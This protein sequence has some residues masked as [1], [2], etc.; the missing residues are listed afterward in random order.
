MSKKSRGKVPATIRK[1]CSLPSAIAQMKTIEEV[2][3]YYQKI[4]SCMP[5]NVFWLDKN[6]ITQ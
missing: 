1:K 5:N 4:I 3:H 2:H 6:C